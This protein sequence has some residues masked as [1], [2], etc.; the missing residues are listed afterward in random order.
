MESQFCVILPPLSLGSH[1]VPSW[2]HL[3]LFLWTAQTIQY[4]LEFSLGSYL[5]PLGS[6]PSNAQTVQY[7]PTFPLGSAFVPLGSSLSYFFRMRKPSNALSQFH[8]VPPLGPLGS[9]P[10]NA[11]TVQY[12]LAFP[13]GS[14]LVPFRSSLS[15]FFHVHRRPILPRSFTWFRLGSTCAC[16]AWADSSCLPAHRLH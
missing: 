4:S 1:L 16:L 8:V 5:V 13:L 10:S 11:Q 6:T 7:S 9:A 15:F 12:S 3:V 14:A 2:F